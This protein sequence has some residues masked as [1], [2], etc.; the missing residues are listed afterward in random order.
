MLLPTA[1]YLHDARTP[2][3]RASHETTVTA[4]VAMTASAALQAHAPVGDEVLVRGGLQRFEP[5]QASVDQHHDDAG[6]DEQAQEEAAGEGD[7][8]V[9]DGVVA[10]EEGKLRHRS[11]P[12]G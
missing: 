4:L 5:L 12:G 10:L 7:L 6:V 8:A 2:H 1:A 11:T 3:T 9:V